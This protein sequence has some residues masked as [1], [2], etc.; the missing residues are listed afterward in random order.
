[1]ALY[2]SEDRGTS[3]E[4]LHLKNG[5]P[6]SCHGRSGGDELHLGVGVSDHKYKGSHGHFVIPSRD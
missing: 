6:L 4:Q 2:N 3:R 5:R 1:M